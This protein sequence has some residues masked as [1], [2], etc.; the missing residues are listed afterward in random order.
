LQPP[1][2]ALVVADVSQPSV[3]MG[4]QS[5][6]GAVQALMQVPLEHLPVALA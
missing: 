3:R 2:W 1:Q 5:A 6:N 4:L